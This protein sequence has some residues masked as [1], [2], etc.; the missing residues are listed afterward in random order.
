MSSPQFVCNLCNKE[1]IAT[2]QN[3]YVTHYCSV[4]CQHK[5]WPKHS[6]ICKQSALAMKAKEVKD[7]KCKAKEL[8]RTLGPDHEDNT[9]FDESSRYIVTGSREFKG[10]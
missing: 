8:E 9:V 7:A 6:P 5:D 3:C 2:C 4:E 1:A 10:S